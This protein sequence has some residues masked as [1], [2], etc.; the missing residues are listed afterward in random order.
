MLLDHNWFVSLYSSRWTHDPGRVSVRGGHVRDSE[1]RFYRSCEECSDVVRRSEGI[2]TVDDCDFFCCEGC[3]E[4][5][6][7]IRR[8]DRW[9]SSD[10][11]DDD[12]DDGVYSYNT[13]LGG[14]VGPGSTYNIGTEIEIE[15]SCNRDRKG[16]VRAIESEFR[17]SHAHCK[18]DGSLGCYGVE[19]ATGYGD[20]AEMSD[21]VKGV[22]AFA[23][24]HGG[25]A[26]TTDSC[27]QHI[28]VSRQ[29]MS[30][31]QQAR[32]VVFF[33]H[34]ANQTLL[35]EFAR[36]P[37]CH[38]ARVIPDKSTKQWVDE[39]VRLN[40]LGRG[41]KYEA[42]NCCHSSHLEVRI[43]RGSLRT[44][45]ALARMA[46]VKNVAVYCEEDLAVEELTTEKFL[47][48]ISTRSCV[49]SGYIKDYLIYRSVKQPALAM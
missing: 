16:F 43:F 38:W 13:Y 47:E 24:D 39:R 9:Y 46:L 30:I 34:P 41:E 22:C 45:T 12:S 23:L 37:S 40:S 11:D 44:D 15:F 4:D 8:G 28:S 33:N 36:R 3:A 32:F 17:P 2:V 10:D 31:P 35:K 19:V 29:N 1:A 18:S 48:W 27:G 20:F 25:R 5:Y 42:V 26:H 21:V 6:G 7:C 49:E 14:L